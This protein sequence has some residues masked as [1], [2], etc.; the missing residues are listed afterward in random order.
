MFS[1]SLL[2][3]LAGRVH[4]VEQRHGNLAVR[5]HDDVARQL[6]LLPELD[7]EHVARYR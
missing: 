5:A 3:R 4:V 7:A 2:R 1:L 6:L